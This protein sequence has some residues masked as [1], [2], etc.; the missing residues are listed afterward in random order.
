M[1]IEL[2]FGQG[3]IV[4]RF[5]VVATIVSIEKRI[6]KMFYHLDDG[7]GT[8][9]AIL[10]VLEFDPYS[11]VALQPPG[12]AASD[13]TGFFQFAL[14]T[15]VRA[16]CRL[17]MYQ[18]C[19]EMLVQTIAPLE[20]PNALPA[21]WLRALRLFRT[22][23]SRP[24]PPVAALEAEP[25]PTHRSPARRRYAR[26]LFKALSAR[27]P[28]PAASGQG[29][30][31]E[32]LAATRAAAPR[33]E[34]PSGRRHELQLSSPARDRPDP[35]GTSLPS[36]GAP[37]LVLATGQGAAAGARSVPPRFRRLA[38]Q[39]PPSGGPPGGSQPAGERHAATAIL[40]ASAAPRPPPAPQRPPGMAA[41][42]LLR[43]LHTR[44][45]Q[46][47]SK[48]PGRA[49]PQ[50]APARP[51][52]P[53]LGRQAGVPSV[54]QPPPGPLLSPRP[55]P[56][57]LPP[58]SGGGGEEPPPPAHP[59]ESRHPYA[60]TFGELCADRA[61]GRAAIEALRADSP[62]EAPVPAAAAAAAADADAPLEAA[63]QARVTLM[64]Q[65]SL[66]ALLAQGLAARDLLCDGYIP[67]DPT[68]LLAPIVLALFRRAPPPLQ[69][70]EAD[71][72]DQELG[73]L[74]R[75]YPPPCRQ[76]L[77]RAG[78]GG[79]ARA[80]SPP[81][82]P[83]PGGPG[84]KRARQLSPGRAAAHPLVEEATDHQHVLGAPLLA[85][86]GA[87]G[88]EAVAGAG[89]DPEA[90]TEG[91]LS[92]WDAVRALRRQPLLESVNELWVR[93][94][95]DLLVHQSLLYKCGPRYRLV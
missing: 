71:E 65:Q 38:G 56:L 41:S 88:P 57:P 49:E 74:A 48:S 76:A 17:R 34:Q 91:G 1:P 13:P 6:E 59:P 84:R 2:P 51:D 62:Q 67:L 10:N 77:M 95:L 89:E 18:G 87:A 70:D 30:L 19:P 92:P 3:H 46:G 58:V 26:L 81:H 47:R 25:L 8:I 78:R 12:P 23:Y 82:L 42:L 21:H 63:A 83:P 80:A 54:P 73:L 40:P 4:T 27:L 35:S 52:G 24:A 11:L 90:P 36:Q 69:A 60:V 32:L 9:K 22:V 29:A 93:R 5:E 75:L 28:P 15:L 20:E 44:Q 43:A 50:Q 64:L 31:E 79:S 14:G 86:D 55:E 68:R 45:L 53:A 39:P 33:A 94:A 7:T 37:P 61:L 66:Q 16:H 72:A 85:G